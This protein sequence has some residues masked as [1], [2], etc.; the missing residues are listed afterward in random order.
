MKKT[1]ISISFA[2]LKN[3]LK[4]VRIFGQAVG[5]IE[6]P[7]SLDNA[8][9]QHITFCMHKNEKAI[10]SLSTTG[11]G[12]VLCRDDIPGLETMTFK[13]CVFTVSNPRLSFIQC[14]QKYFKPQKQVGVHQTAIIDEGIILP[15]NVYIGPLVHI[16]SGAKIGE[17]TVIEDRVYIGPD[18]VIGRN[19]YIQAGVVIG[20]AGQGF[21]RTETGEFEK[22]PQLGNVIIEDDV[23]IGANTTIV[24]GSL[25]STR[26]GK[27]SKIGHQVN[28]GH[29]TNIGSHVFISAGAVVCGSTRIG[30]FAWLAPTSCIRNKVTIGNNVTVGLG[31]VVVKDVGEGLTVIGMPAKEISIED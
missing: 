13:T 17:E 10:T 16:C 19:V 7:A 27:G 15:Q 6:A 18:T 22:F 14:L 2:D 1:I 5:Q 25:A 23:E 21:E 3:Y 30:D 24:R 8:Q 31:A 9:R 28:I 29:N 12:L 4:P 11:A 26:I 20:C